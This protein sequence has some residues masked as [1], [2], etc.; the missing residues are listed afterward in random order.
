MGTTPRGASRPQVRR[1]QGGQG[2]DKG[3]GGIGPSV[4]GPSAACGRMSVLTTRTVLALH[5]EGIEV[6]HHAQEGLARRRWEGLALALAA[7]LLYGPAIGLMVVTLRWDVARTVR[8]AELEALAEGYRIEAVCWREL[9]RTRTHVTS[10]LAE[11]RWVR[12]C[13]ARKAEGGEG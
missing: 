13:L 8:V 3:A 4:W 1:S 6:L 9:A 12:D 7:L 11:S 5:P 10:W 2:G